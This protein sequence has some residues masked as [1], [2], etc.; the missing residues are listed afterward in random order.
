[1]SLFFKPVFE[2]WT[3]WEATPPN[4]K[5][6]QKDWLIQPNKGARSYSPVPLLLTLHKILQGDPSAGEPGLGWQRV[7]IS[8]PD[9]LC[10]LLIP[11]PTITH[12]NMW[13]RLP[14]LHLFALSHCANHDAK[15]IRY[16]ECTQWSVWHSTN[17]GRNV[18]Y[19]EL[20]IHGRL[21]P[22]PTP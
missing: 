2:H 11:R 6:R 17:K 4:R 7:Q 12:A 19:V 22:G 3:G 8:P 15:D 21:H 9:L 13:C 1:M 10:P 16:T 20:W 5:G 14:S 18:L